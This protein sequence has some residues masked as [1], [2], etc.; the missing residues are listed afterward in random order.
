MVVDDTR[1]AWGGINVPGLPLVLDDSNRIV[2]VTSR[3]VNDVST[4][5][6]VDE[7]T[8]ADLVR[9]AGSL[10]SSKVHN[11]V[12]LEL[13]G[14]CACSV[15][16]LKLLSAEFDVCKPGVPSDRGGFA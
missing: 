4:T 12:R 13:R 9:Q 16:I 15:S 10:V 11:G 1:P 8:A 2:A 5:V 7:A 14:A 6:D 3:K